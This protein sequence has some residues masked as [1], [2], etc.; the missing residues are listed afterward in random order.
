PVAGADTVV[1]LDGDRLIE[2]GGVS[3]LTVTVVRGI[4]DEDC[5]SL[6]VADGRYV[7]HESFGLRLGWD[8]GGPLFLMDATFCPRPGAEPRS[9]RLASFNY[10]GRFVRVR[11]GLLGLD[12]EVAGDTYA[13]ETSFLITRR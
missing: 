7:R 10:P 9:V 2:A 8:D 6:R 4:A 1:A 11:G 3:G 12:P 5:L 13:E